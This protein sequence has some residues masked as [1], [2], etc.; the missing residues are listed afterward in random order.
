M[1]EPRLARGV[2]VDLLA[3][4]EGLQLTYRVS[5]RLQ[6]DRRVL[7]AFRVEVAPDGVQIQAL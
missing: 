7:L 5:A 4:D 3:A 1:Y 2:A 6:R